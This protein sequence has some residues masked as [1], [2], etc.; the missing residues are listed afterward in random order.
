MDLDELLRWAILSLQVIQTMTLVAWRRCSQATRA[1]AG[2]SGS[3]KRAGPGLTGL[4]CPEDSRQRIRSISD[5]LTSIQIE[6]FWMVNGLDTPYNWAVRFILA[7]Y[8][9]SMFINREENHCMP[10]LCF[11]FA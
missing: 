5:G 1:G 7:R 4:C 9:W 10:K 2:S 8:V 6:P 11:I 3:S